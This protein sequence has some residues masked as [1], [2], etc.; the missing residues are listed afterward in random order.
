[1]SISL[2]G[3]IKTSKG[4]KTVGSFKSILKISVLINTYG[5]M[6]LVEV[7]LKLIISMGEKFVLL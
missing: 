5:C 6:L 4:G 7:W 1:M 3:S 2:S